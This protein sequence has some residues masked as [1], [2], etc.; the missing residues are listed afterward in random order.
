[1]MI[2]SII[3]YFRVVRI[4]EELSRDSGLGLI[5]ASQGRKSRLREGPVSPRDIINSQFK[6]NM[7]PPA[8]SSFATLVYLTCL[9]RHAQSDQC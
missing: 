6:G 1:M 5:A 7:E 8:W 2:A 4:A 3:R 9:I